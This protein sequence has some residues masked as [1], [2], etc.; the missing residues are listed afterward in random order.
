[1]SAAENSNPAVLH[2]WSRNGHLHPF[3]SWVRICENGSE[4]EF[5]IIPQR[6]NFA[7]W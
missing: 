5:I 1:M 7:F 6:W 3:G 4:S 2:A